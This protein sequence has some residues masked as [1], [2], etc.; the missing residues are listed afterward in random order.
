MLINTQHL[1]KRIISIIKLLLLEFAHKQWIPTSSHNAAMTY[2]AIPRTKAL[3]ILQQLRD[4]QIQSAG[5]DFRGVSLVGEDLSNLDLSGADLSES[6]LTTADLSNSR[7]FKTNLRRAS[8][9]KANLHGAEFTGSDFT[10]ANLEEVKGKNI[11]LGMS[12]LVGARMFHADLE[13]GTLTKANLRHADMSCTNLSNSRIREADCTGANFTGANF[14][15]ADLS[16]SRVTGVMFNNSDLREAHLRQLHD[17]EHAEWY[18]VDIRD[19]NFAGA[20]R[21]RR[22]IIDENY[23]KEFRDSSRFANILYYLWLI[24]SDCGR[25]LKL[26]FAW[27]F[28]L[29]M[30]FAWLYTMVSIDYGTNRTWISPFYYSVVTLTTLGYGDNVPLSSAGRI[31]AMLEVCLGYVMLGGML[32]LFNNKMARRGD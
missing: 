5:L 2:K 8:L 15:G 23:L 14:Y 26:W 9:H 27:T 18:G 13:G 6:D 32:S 12:T 20:Y 29:T 17:F 19:I 11:G 31:I 7:F 25:S 22:H 28:A 30:F 10:E 16:L 24:T 3:D 4:G 21:L 1:T